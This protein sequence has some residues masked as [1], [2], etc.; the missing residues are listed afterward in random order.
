MPTK[1]AAVGSNPQQHQQI[2]QP[3]KWLICGVNS[4]PKLG[5]SQ[6]LGSTMGWIAKGLEFTARSEIDPWCV[7]HASRLLPQMKQLGDLESLTADNMVLS[8]VLIVGTTFT[9]VS[10]LGMQR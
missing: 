3:D 8:D 4:L 5:T 1:Q 2:L 6:V 9:A 10:T 7:D